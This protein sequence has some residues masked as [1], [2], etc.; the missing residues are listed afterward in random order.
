MFIEFPFIGIRDHVSGHVLRLIARVRKQKNPRLAKRTWDVG[1][2]DL[3][4]VVASE[5]KL[6]NTYYDVNS[7]RWRM[8]STSQAHFHI[9]TANSLL[10]RANLSPS[11]REISMAKMPSKYG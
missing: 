6:A 5:E 9:A 10:T 7:F 11:L 2:L 4:G 8:A 1:T 3:D